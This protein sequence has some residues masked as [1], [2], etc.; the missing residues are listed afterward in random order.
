VRNR[1]DVSRATKRLQHRGPDGQR[2][3]EIDLSTGDQPIANENER[4]RI[5]VN[6]EF[7]GYEA[8]QRE[9]KAIPHPIWWVELI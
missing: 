6:G 5:V 8:M 9:L 4:T 1:R 2:G 7:Y 3:T